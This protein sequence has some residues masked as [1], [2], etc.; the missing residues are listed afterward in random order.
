MYAIEVNKV[1]KKYKNG[2]QALDRLS[3]SVQKGQIFSLLGQNGAGKS[4]LIRILTTYLQ[5]TAGEVTMLGK[6]IYSEAAAIR[7]EIACVSQHISID[8]H[9]SLEENMIFQSRLYKI[10][11]AAA[12]K[13]MEKLIADFDLSKYRK[14]PVSSYS[15][16]VKRRLDIALNMMSNPHILFLDE[17]TVGMDI[18]SR[19]AMWD[20][21]RKI[22]DDFGTTIFLTTH[23]LEEAD[24]LS[25]A[26]CIMKGGKEAIQGSPDTLKS[27]LRQS[28]IQV[29]FADSKDAQKYLPFCSST[30]PLKHS[31]Y[32]T[33]LYSVIPVMNIPAWPI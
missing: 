33:P 18:Q 22:R 21:M 25:D 5:P 11:K 16:G 9:L 6:D 12:Q 30:S 31:L 8:T 27:I 14:Y 17:P 20:M 29:K 28:V 4:T 23:Y 10:P 32:G 2:V 19:M 3:L 15:G 7:S 24:Q 26:I 13:R 1:V